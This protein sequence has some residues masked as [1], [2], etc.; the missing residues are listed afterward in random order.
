MFRGGEECPVIFASQEGEEK[1]RE[2]K[3]ALKDTDFQIRH[4]LQNTCCVYGKMRSE[5][6]TE[7]HTRKTCPVRGSVAHEISDKA[8]RFTQKVCAPLWPGPLKVNYIYFIFGGGE[9]NANLRERLLWRELDIN[10]RS[11][12]VVGFKWESCFFLFFFL[13]DPWWPT[14]LFDV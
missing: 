3:K 9:V 13:G 1:K 12:A 4:P 14:S 8:A 11:F 10:L 2:K 7:T 6:L 5:K